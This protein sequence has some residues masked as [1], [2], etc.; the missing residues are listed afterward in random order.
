MQKFNEV[1]NMIPKNTYTYNF[2]N[3]TATKV[4]F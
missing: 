2:V 4:V 3:L 1:G